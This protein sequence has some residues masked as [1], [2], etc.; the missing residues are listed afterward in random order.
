VNASAVVCFG[1]RFESMHS[2]KV[3]RLLN[4]GVLDYQIFI[5][6]SSQKKTHV[7]IMQNENQGYM[8]YHF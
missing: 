7:K 1:K 5:T 2:L 4:N 3:I 6:F 8:A